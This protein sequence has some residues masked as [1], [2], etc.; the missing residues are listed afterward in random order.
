M[1]KSFTENERE[2]IKKRL[3]EEAK[4]CLNLYGIKKTTVDELVKRVNIPKGT[5]YLFYGSKELLLFDVIN[6]VHDEIQSQIIRELQALNANIDSEA[7]T[8]LLFSLYKKVENTFLLNILTNGEL[9]LLMRK[10]P[11]DTVEEHLAQDDLIIEKVLGI[12]PHKNDVD[13][14]YFSGALRGIFMSMLHKR[15]IGEDIFD[16][17]LK[18]M[19][20]GIAIQLTEV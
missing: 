20:K 3:K 10:L 17:S 18:L 1:P 4:E 11:L 12:I 5:F 16:G 14:K 6:D 2:Y 15:E 19:I 13:I 9:E 7:L 8:E